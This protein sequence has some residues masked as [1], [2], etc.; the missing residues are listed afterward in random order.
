MG[1]ADLDVE[2]VLEQ[3]LG[4][5]GGGGQELGVGGGHGAGQ[6]TCQHHTG[7]EGQQDAVAAH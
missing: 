3:I 4:D 2:E 6:D 7:N 1:L 5:A